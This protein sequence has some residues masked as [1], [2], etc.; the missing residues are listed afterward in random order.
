MLLTINNIQMQKWYDH[1]PFTIYRGLNLSTGQKYWIKMLTDEYPSQHEIEWITNEYENGKRIRLE[2]LL[3][4]LRLDSYHSTMMLVMEH[5][6]G[7]PL[8]QLTASGPMELKLFLFLSVSMTEIIRKLHQLKYVHLNVSSNAFVVQPAYHKVQL[9]D[10][11]AAY[12]LDSAA[13][14]KPTAELR[15]I[16]LPFMAPEQFGRMDRNIDYR[17][18]VYSLGVVFYEM[19]T[20]ERPFSANDTTEWIHHHMAKQPVA[21]HKAI[22]SIPK[23]VSDIVMKC[24]AKHP[25]H[26]YQSAFAL[27]SD[28]EACLTIL[29]Q[30]GKLDQSPIEVGQ[31]ADIFKISDSLYGREQELQDLRNAYHRALLGSNEMVFVSGLSG[32]GKSYLIQE[33]QKSILKEEGLFISG[34][35][36]QFKRDTPFQAIAQAGLQLI[37]YLLSLSD[38][39]FQIWKRKILD[40]VGPNGHILIDVIPEMEKVIGPQP[41]L[42]KLPPAEMHNRFLITVQQF[43]S[44][45]ATKENPLIVFIDDLQWADPASLQLLQDL[46]SQPSTNCCLFIGT[47]RSNDVTEAHPLRWLIDKLDRMHHIQLV[48]IELEPL[49]ILDVRHLLHDTLRKVSDDQ[50]NELA[51]IIIEKTKGNPFFTKQ[52]LRSLYDHQLVQFNYEIGMWQWDLG[53]I[54][55]LHITDNVVDFMIN[56]IR[57]LPDQVQQLLMHA[58][59]IGHIFNTDLLALAASQEASAVDAALQQAVKEGLLMP[60]KA[61]EANGS[62]GKYSFL[63]DRVH[64]AV[65]SMVPKLQKKEL[66][67]H[68]GK[69]LYTTLS[70][71]ELEEHLFDVANQFNQGKELLTTT[72]DRERLAEFNVRASRKAKANTAYETALKYVTHSVQL[73]DTNSWNHQYDL[74][75]SIYLELAELEYLCGHFEEA[76]RSFQLILSHASTRMEKADAYNLMMVLYT[77]LGLH[78]QA[79]EMGLEGL[80]L[81]GIPLQSTISRSSILLELAKTKWNMIAKQPEDLFDLP[82]MI[83]PDHKAVVRLMINLIAPSYFLNSDLYVFLMMKLFNFSLRYGNSEGSSLA[84]STYGVIISSLFGDVKGGAKFGKA[85]LLLCDSFDHL[86]IKCKVY[87]GFGAF[88]NNVTQHIE[89][90]VLYLKKAYQFG[91]ESGDFVYGGYSI[92]FSFFL[93]LYKGDHLGEVYTETELYHS[94]VDRSQDKDTI[95]ILLVLQRFMLFMKDEPAPQSQMNQ[96]ALLEP[97]MNEDERLQLGSFSNKAVVHT[98]YAL[99]LQTFYMLDR[100]QEA[101][102]LLEQMEESIHSVFGLIHVQM[103]HFTS[104]LVLCALYPDASKAEQSV[105]WRKLRKNLKVLKKWSAHA[106]E[107]FLHQQLLIEAEMNRIAGNSSLAAEQYEQA[108]LHAGKQHFVHIEAMA[109][110]CAAKFYMQTGKM[111]IARSYWMEAKQLYTKWGAQRKVAQLEDKHPYLI[112]RTPSA[113]SVIDVSTFMKASQALSNEA[114]FHKLLESFMH[115]VM[116]N[117][118]AEKGLLVLVRDHRLYVEVEKLPDQPFKAQHAIPM[119]DY[120]HAAISAI[121]YAVRKEEPLLLHDAASSD[122]F[123]KDVY[124][125]TQLPKSVLVL[126]IIKLGKMIGALYLENNLATHVFQE[127]RLDTLKLLTSEIASTIENAKLYTNLEYKDYKL[128]LLEEREKNIQLQLDEKERW[129]QSSEATMLNIRKAQHELINNVQTVH[130]LLMMNKYDMAKEYISVWCKEIVQQS[131]VNSVK[132]PVL[133]VVLNNISLPC[134]SNKIE[135]QVT[136]KLDC[137]FEGITLPISYFSS[138]VHNLL[139]NAIEAIPDD[140]PLRT[141]RLTIEEDDDQYKLIVFNTGSFIPEANRLKIFDKG[142]STKSDTTNSGLGLNIVHTYLQHYNGSIECSSVEGEGTTFTVSLLKQNAAPLPPSHSKTLKTM[143]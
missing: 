24:L 134:I 25:E 100:I 78:E 9:T 115:I 1:E 7:Q 93:R 35:F 2:E 11:N 33:F 15:G 105:Y 96:D 14:L 67:Y 103:Y 133:G 6:E 127:Q 22:P 16:R 91:V 111:K 34:K 74:T 38:E 126:P 108:I 19:L 10:L 106:P 80:R 45:F 5:S 3:Q 129:V 21:P 73:L 29:L 50:V 72:R 66:H 13:G 141:L 71:E 68:V 97:F 122:M 86:P 120:G 136:G 12:S 26:R 51:D 49:D 52:F 59:C 85:G 8:S 42:S 63:H 47:Y 132:F 41:L 94:F 98:Y 4:P 56:K 124:I 99:Q 48:N 46:S 81:F 40:A 113:Q 28:L 53:K 138:I 112:S 101:K 32:V 57:R 37:Q 118:G 137:T 58:A 62:A 139:K 117:A 104:S 142:F 30:E 64:Q 83:D 88:T 109:N 89:S 77:N 18:D 123:P 31:A 90:N 61:D 20:G 116:E 69:L 23:P 110:E 43:I 36:E 39:P 84:Y 107:T 79:L 87:F 75:F 60:V 76:K 102:Q 17:T 92:T 130:A 119:E 65:Y 70:P 143:S 55:E 44:V 125:R 140:D 114:V 121:Q 82:K 27:K 54:Q 131:V 128:Q 135:L 95:Y